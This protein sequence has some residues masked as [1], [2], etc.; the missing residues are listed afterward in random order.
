VVERESEKRWGAVPLIYMENDIPQV[1]V[2]DEP[3]GLWEYGACC[4]GN[5]SAG[6]SVAYVMS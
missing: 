2:G 3:S 6:R 5:R 1:K 4:L